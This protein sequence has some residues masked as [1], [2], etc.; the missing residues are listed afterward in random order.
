MAFSVKQVATIR[1]RAN[2]TRRE[3]HDYHFQVHGALSTGPTLEETPG[4]YYQT[5]FF[6]SAYQSSSSKEPGYF[7]HDDMTELYYKD[8]AHV[9]HVFG[10]EY[11]KTK[12]GPDGRN[13]SDMAS[14]MSMFSREEII[15]GP[16]DVPGE[17]LVAKYHIQG[18]GQPDDGTSLASD[19]RSSIVSNFAPLAKGITLDIRVPDTLD[20]LKYFG[21]QAAP[22]MSLIVTVYLKDRENSI[23]AFRRAQREFEDNVGEKTVKDVAFVCFGKRALVF[24]HTRNIPFDR[25]RQP[26]L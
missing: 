5:H 22:N 3:F 10:S 4:A 26:I 21:V 24:D 1:R 7:G 13:F 11:V 14:A 15:H 18:N 2:M 9:G 25:S 23:T 8:L 16:A 19:L 6:D 20:I 17:G 12:V